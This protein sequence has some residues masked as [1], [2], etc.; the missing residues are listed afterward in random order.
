MS[1]S[2]AKT[3]R[4]SLGWWPAGLLALVLSSSAWALDLD[5]EIRRQDADSAQILNTLG[6]GKRPNQETSKET[7][8]NVK[9]EMIRAA[10][11]SR[12]G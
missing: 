10:E 3:D 2:I 1:G 5:Q 7:D 12:E 9:I 4:L 6:R 11:R 8:K